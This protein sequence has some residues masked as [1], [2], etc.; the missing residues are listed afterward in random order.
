MGDD[1]VIGGLLRQTAVALRH[2]H[3]ERPY[4]TARAEL[5]LPSQADPE[6]CR[7]E[8]SVRADGGE[9]LAWHGTGPTLAAASA[10]CVAA[11]AFDPLARL[12]AEARELGYDLVPKLKGA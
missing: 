9:F 8:Y 3:P 7:P 11:M 2:A 12:R 1:D 4:V 6:D 10:E 5:R